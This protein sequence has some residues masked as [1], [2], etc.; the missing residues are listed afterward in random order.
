MDSMIPA[1]QNIPFSPRPELIECRNHPDHFHQPNNP[2]FEGNETGRVGGT[3]TGTTVL[4]G[5]AV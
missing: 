2:L 1:E 5:L 3:D 4:D